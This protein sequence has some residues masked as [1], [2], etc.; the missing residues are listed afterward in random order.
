MCIYKHLT[1]ENIRTF[2]GKIILNRCKIN[3]VC[4]YVCVC[5]GLNVTVL[6]SC[7]DKG[8]GICDFTAA[9]LVPLAAS[10]LPV[11]ELLFEE[12]LDGEE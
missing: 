8:G 3:K 1:F 11:A 12:R 7:K 10:A 6:L 9:G 4:V 2:I 5:V